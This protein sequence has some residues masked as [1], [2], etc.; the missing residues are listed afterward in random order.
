MD[1]SKIYV[2][3]D[4]PWKLEPNYLNFIIDGF[5]C[6]INRVAPVGHLC[7]YVAV[8]LKHPAAQEEDAY[9]LDL[10]VHGGITFSQVG[11][12]D[13]MFYPKNKS[14][15]N[16]FWI[17]FDCAHYGDMTPQL[18]K[19]TGLQQSG[20]YRTVAYVRKEIENLVRQLK[21]MQQKSE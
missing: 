16:L 5:D 7:G 6:I 15:H 1:L 20:T 12:K 14:G 19:I 8:P 18:Y 17:G 13:S 21:E 10:H 4:E 9:S 11:M 3:R 2:S